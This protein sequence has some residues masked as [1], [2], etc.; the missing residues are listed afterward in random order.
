MQRP[1]HEVVGDPVVLLFDH[2]LDGPC[3]LAENNEDQ[4]RADSSSC[5]DSRSKDDLV[6]F[7]SAS[8]TLHQILE[9]EPLVTTPLLHP[10]IRARF[11]DIKRSISIPHLLRLIPGRL[12]IFLI[13]SPFQLLL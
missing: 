9:M 10:L 12:F 6:A 7:S 2:P 3:L 11:I 1:V 13:S 5:R 8:F 4:L